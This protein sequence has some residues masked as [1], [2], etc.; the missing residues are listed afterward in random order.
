MVGKELINSLDLH[1]IPLYGVHSTNTVPISG[2][3]PWDKMKILNDIDNGIA[4]FEPEALLGTF[5]RSSL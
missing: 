5:R 2:I 4:E 3:L 1:N